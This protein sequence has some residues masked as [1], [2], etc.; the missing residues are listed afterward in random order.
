MDFNNQVDLAAI[1]EQ[2]QNATDIFSDIAHYIDTEAEEYRKT[3]SIWF[4]MLKV[5]LCLCWLLAELSEKAK[6]EF[7]EAQASLR[8]DY[9]D[10]INETITEVSV[11]LLLSLSFVFNKWF[12]L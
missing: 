3:V 8:Y 2:I 11:T 10:S 5:G 1:E 9:L 6:N 12:F 7:E 4:S